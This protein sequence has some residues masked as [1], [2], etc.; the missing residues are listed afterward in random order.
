MKIPSVRIIRRVLIG[1]I[2]AV[3]LA[4][5]VNYLVVASRRPRGD[6]NRPTMISADFRHAA[7]GVEILVRKGSVRRFTVRAN[8][9]RETIQD[10]S[11]LEGI[12]ASD[13]NQDGSVR[14]SIY[15]DMAVYDQGRKM[16]D[17]DGDVRVFLGDGSE[18]RAEALHYDLD[19][20][21]GVIPGM[22]E[23]LSNNVSG[24]ARDA[25]FFRDEDRLDLGGEADFS[26]TRENTTGSAEE[27]DGAIRAFA[28]R[29][30]C[31]LAENLIMFSGGVRI[32]SHDTGALSA[33]T[34]DIKLNSG[35]SKITYMTA[36]GKVAYEM[37]G[38][39]GTRSVSGGRMVFT[40]GTTGALEK[41][42]ISEY[43]NLLV[44]SSDGERTLRSGEIELFMNS[45]SGAISEIIGTTGA[46]LRD[47]RGAAET[48]ASGDVIYAAFAGTG[49]R[50]GNVR[51]SGR[52]RFSAAEAGK[53][54]NEL[55]AD[56]IEA[57]FRADGEG[58]ECLESNGGV[59][60]SFES[61][62]AAAR[63]MFA[64]KLEVLY[65][66]NYPESGEATGAV[67]LEESGAAARATRRLSAEHMRFD[68][69][70]GANQI[71]SLT[72][73]DG[74]S[75]VY[76]RSVSPF[77]KAD[78]E[79]Y[80][81]FSDGME[82]FFVQGNGAAALLRAEQRGNF[83]FISGG[84]SASADRGEYDAG[85]RKLTL[86]GSPE[87][88]DE[89]GRVNGDRIEYDLDANELL[90]RGRV[91]AMLDARKNEGALFQTGFQAGNRSGVGASPV[92]AISEELRYRTEEK[93]FR[94][95]G[96]VTVLTERQ[97]LGAGEITIDGGGNMTA[98]GGVVHRIHETD[99]GG[100]AAI[101]SLQ[102]EY[103]RGEGLI[104]YSGKVEMK[105]GD[106]TFSS[107]TLNVTLDDEAKDIRRILAGGNVL[108]RHGGRVCRGNTAEWIP[109]SAGYVVTGDPA[110]FDDPARGRSMARRL[111]YF[112]GEDRITLEP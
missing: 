91:R 44:K 25:R 42:R 99:Q 110:V 34:A 15:S 1:V 31:L 107:D 20:E 67:A 22:M 18:L 40:T 39:D 77:G 88:I 90:A 2:G 53:A 49:G 5:L 21:I 37:R 64:S 27:P 14:N 29:G 79:S 71:K 47:R 95:S 35:R 72:A 111:T 70:P 73:K 58:I 9:L 55:R 56:A 108:V 17:F 84:R 63:T 61:P 96:G 43:A 104:R 94:F 92:V 101:E 12:E 102:M 57:R 60:W 52:S 46:E 51:L 54:A 81:T 16:L 28:A 59:R 32:E 83:R 112:Q 19:K 3:A 26:L 65:A 10:R 89:A 78:V 66:G 30:T 11:F 105:S 98:D 75:V 48:L 13:F 8:R 86:T 36:S 7:E 103:R 62:D 109:A 50:L 45:V 87:I 106:L 80:R 97:Q 38:M 23:F 100:A 24:R 76:H 4:A 41:V 33:D 82:V 85:K 68:F 69:F 93:R 74:V 6:G